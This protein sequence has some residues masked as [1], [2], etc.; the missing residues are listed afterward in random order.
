M[1]WISHPLLPVSSPRFIWNSISFIMPGQLR[2]CR[3]SLFPLLK[4]VHLPGWTLLCS[5]LTQNA[6]YLLCIR[7][8]GDLWGSEHHTESR[9]FHTLEAG[10]GIRIKRCI[11]LTSLEFSY[12]VWTA[13]DVSTKYIPSRSRKH[14]KE[15]LDF[16]AN[17]C[18]LVLQ[19]RKECYTSWSLIYFLKNFSW[20]LICF[21]CPLLRL[22]F[23]S[24]G[25]L[26]M[27]CFFVSDSVQ[28]KVV[29]L[30]KPTRCHSQHMPCANAFPICFLLIPG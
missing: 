5:Y 13:Q 28:F 26:Q 17:K 7:W 2:S 8:C 11:H 22:P 29:S 9:A 23:T 16:T 1:L 3:L 30:K 10:N 24:Y 21:C 14:R 6:D 15:R 25:C 19:K 20:I 27:Y 4:Q 12:K 18:I